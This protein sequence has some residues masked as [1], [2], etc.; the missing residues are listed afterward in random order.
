MGRGGGGRGG[1]RGGGGGARGGGRGGGGG[2]R[3]KGRG[4]AGGARRRKEKEE[5]KKEVKI[6]REDRRHM[7]QYGEQHPVLDNVD[8]SAGNAHQRVVNLDENTT[9]AH[10]V[11]GR[12]GK[13]THQ[14]P[15]KRPVAPDPAEVAE[16]NL[17]N[18]ESDDEDQLT[19]YQRLVSMVKP[20]VKF[21]AILKRRKL[22]DEREAQ[23]TT[24][25]DEGALSDSDGRE[26]E[27]ELNDEELKARMAELDDDMEIVAV[28]G[29][30][31]DDSG[32]TDGIDTE[33]DCDDADENE[34]DDDDDDDDDGG[35]DDDNL[36]DDSSKEVTHMKND[37]DVDD[38][39]C[40]H[41]FETRYNIDISS[42]S[43]VLDLKKKI[44][45]FK[46]PG[47][48]VS[49][50]TMPSPSFGSMLS[51]QTKH[52]PTVK[53]FK[54][55]QTVPSSL[56]KKRLRWKNEAGLE[57]GNLV[58]SSLQAELFHYLTAYNDILF[59]QRTYAMSDSIRQMY[60]L[61]VLNHVLNTRSRVLKNSVKLKVLE[62]TGKEFETEFRDQGFT[63][64]KVLIL[65]PYRSCVVKIVEMMTR[66]LVD[67]A[68]MFPYDV[69]IPYLNFLLS[70]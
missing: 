4:G 39:S 8:N 33:N 16:K 7:Q 63:R 31:D 50:K 53:V 6:S 19:A 52:F 62:E 12:G 27:A 15:G 51:S 28:D 37:D 60:V 68:V 70:R 24:G 34:N 69:I 5:S 13:F 23:L 10:A 49:N 41:M 40:S 45:A 55:G 58:L 47:A 2:K 22:A 66:L 20:R 17:S 14:R 59:P 11:R 65:V 26:E 44:D 25:D 48:I 67:P 21:D 32:D 57:N 38:G 43:S 54:D 29:N 64:P 18:D 46:L 35:G 61:H 42:D 30:S 3:G 56:I 9:V 1:G 36:N